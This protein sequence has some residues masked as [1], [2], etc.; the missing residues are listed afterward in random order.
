MAQSDALTIEVVFAMPLTQDCTVVRVPPGATLRAAIECSGVLQRHPTIDLAS[1][2][3]GIWGRR[4]GLD[5]PVH[6]G[7][8]VEIYRPLQADPKEARRTRA[9]RRSL[10]PGG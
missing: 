8:R 3:V 1:C 4:A 9:R 6:D 7:D 5:G 2:R 10:N